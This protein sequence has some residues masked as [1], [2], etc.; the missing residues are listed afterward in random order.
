[1]P[2]LQY[3]MYSGNFE[4]VC[5]TETWLG[6]NVTDG[7]IDQLDYFHVILCDRLD[8]RGGRVCILVSKK[9]DVVEMPVTN[10]I[11]HCI[12]MACIDI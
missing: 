12:E 2:E 10:Y 8:L 1:M 6:D 4:V 5:V 11:F 7:L 3:L 9:L